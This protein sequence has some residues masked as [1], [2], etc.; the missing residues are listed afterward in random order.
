MRIFTAAEI[1]EALS[2]DGEFFARV[3]STLTCT[4]HE[5]GLY[6]QMCPVHAHDQDPMACICQLRKHRRD[7]RDCPVHGKLLFPDETQ[8]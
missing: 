4:C 7:Q 3:R 5:G 2:D 6:A 8:L 1:E